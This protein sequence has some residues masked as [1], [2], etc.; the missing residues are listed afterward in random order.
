MFKNIHVI[1]DDKFFY[2]AYRSFEENYGD[3]NI[4]L[5]LVSKRDKR[6]NSYSG[7]IYYCNILN[8][9]C[10]IEIKNIIVRND[11]KR[12]F[13]HYA[14]DLKVSFVS[15]YLVDKKIKL[16]WIFFG[17]D[18]YS[19][20]NKGSGLFNKK[21][22]PNIF[23]IPETISRIV[24]RF[25]I[26]IF[27]IVYLNRIN[28]NTFRN[29]CKRVDFFCFWNEYDYQI[30]LDNFKTS[31]KLKYFLYYR[32]L[33]KQLE[34]NLELKSKVLVNH[35][36]S[37]SGNHIA[38]FEKLKRIGFDGEI[39]CPISYGNLGMSKIIKQR[40]SALFGHNFRYLTN[41]LPP[42]DYYSLLL[43]VK[44]AVFG[45][46]RQEA[47]ANIF[48]MLKFGAKIFLRND[49]SILKWLRVRGFVVFSFEDDLNALS[50]LGELDSES[51]ILNSRKYEE[52][53]NLNKEAEMFE[54][55]YEC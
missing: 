18:L 12:A 14:N 15:A 23:I 7:N 32:L 54:K 55:L 43:E 47:A 35:S 33:P 30:F 39:I 22:F 19:R 10:S 4:Y 45:H 9:K 34:T 52:Y 29:F 24:L 11:L 44:V 2:P 51:Q 50:D 31:A 38:V 28:T 13:I 36:A 25:R 5:C 3:S 37:R 17:A 41:F 8:K 46:Q 49:N 53:F 27:H 26:F 42:T 6:V 48:I 40:G 1:D 21:V 16:F 20:L